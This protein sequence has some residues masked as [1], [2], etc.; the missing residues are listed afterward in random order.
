MTSKKLN[1]KSLIG[2]III[3]LIYLL[4]YILESYG[5]NIA[6]S[7]NIG[8]APLVIAA[9]I[10]LANTGV[11]ALAK[12]WSQRRAERRN[13]MEYERALEDD[14]ANWDRDR[15]A[16]IQDW[17]RQNEYNDPKKQVERMK[18]AG[19]NPALMYGQGASGS[20]GMAGNIDTPSGG[21]APSPSSPKYE[22][23]ITPGD[24][25]SFA[26]L[27]LQ[28]EQQ[29]LNAQNMEAQ[30]AL[31][32]AQILK[33]LADTD[34]RN[35]NTSLMKDTYNDLVAAASITN[36]ESTTNIEL[37]KQQMLESSQRIDES[38][39]RIQKMAVD[40]KFTQDENFRKQLMSSL[41]RGKVTAQ[42]ELLIQQ[43]L[44]EESKRMSMEAQTAKSQAEKEA[45]DARRQMLEKELEY[46]DAAKA[47]E[48]T[49]T[50][51]GIFS[52]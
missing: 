2:A 48:W 42:T 38:K 19:I 25:T 20:S 13:D 4:N 41:E 27:A 12:R 5:F 23:L 31:I 34:Y 49:Q 17:Q 9:G 33:T 44:T 30:Q 24:G 6:E 3:V 14:R 43:K 22:P 51:L 50:I 29:R 36:K 45:I 1:K 37:K 32:K 18:A 16:A 21:S 52:R 39:K 40:M 15:N 8:I 26:Q 47:R 11:G 7:C 10:G 46:F 28:Q 35:V